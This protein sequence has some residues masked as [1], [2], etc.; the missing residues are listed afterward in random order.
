M[1]TAIKEIDTHIDSQKVIQEFYQAFAAKLLAYTRKNYNINEDDA[2][3]IVYKTIYRMAEVHD[4]YSFE[5]EQKRNAFVFKTH[6]NY[7]R[8]Y[9]RDNKSFENRNFEVELRDFESVNEEVATDVNPKLNM[10]QQL[11]DK[12]E[13][14]ER[15][16]LLMRGQD[17]PYSEI[18]KFV[19]KPEKQLKVYYARL[20]KK[21]L[22]D[23]N[24]TLNKI[25][26]EK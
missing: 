1:N 13:D 23:M 16:L 20:K 19:H 14:W 8:N 2:L 25:S 26:G 10:L 17:M 15:I 18:S 11:L 3:S 5:N 21:L 6:I 4:R 12:M 22:E 9:Y 7:L 24:E